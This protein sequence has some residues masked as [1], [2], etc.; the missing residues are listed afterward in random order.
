MHV[1]CFWVGGP[2][3]VMLGVHLWAPMETPQNV[4]EG[5]PTLPNGDPRGHQ[6]DRSS[7]RRHVHNNN[8]INC[9]Q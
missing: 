7:H 6:L 8:A 4:T 3:S 1:V 9:Q 2:I 5:D